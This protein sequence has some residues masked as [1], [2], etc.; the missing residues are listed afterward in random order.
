MNRKTNTTTA[1]LSEQPAPTR[2][3]LS[4][5]NELTLAVLPTLTVL[6]VLALVEAWSKQRLLFA[7]LASS[8]FLIYLDPQHGS[9][10]VRTLVL[11]QMLAALI[12]FGAFSIFGPGYFAAAGAMVAVITL[13][14]VWG[15]LHPPAVSTSLAFA[16]RSGDENNLL[17]FGL[18]VGLIAV[19]VLLQRFSS[20]LLARYG[21][22]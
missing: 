9:N 8:A 1:P 22:H 19:L 14:I 6:A 16:F 17:L 5:R 18:S 10:S 20:W 13:M 7:S 2:R 21:T 15:V 4:I 3:R 12:G 11:S